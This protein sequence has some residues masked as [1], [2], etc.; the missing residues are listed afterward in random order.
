M[1]QFTLVYEFTTALRGFH[2]YRSEWTPQLDQSIKFKP[3]L[4]NPY[5]SSLL[6]DKRIFLESSV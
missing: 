6:L 2:V 1:A 4:K 5:E 3:Q